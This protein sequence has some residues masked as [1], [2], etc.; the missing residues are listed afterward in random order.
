M[1]LGALNLTHNHLEPTT[2][3]PSKVLCELKYHQKTALTWLLARESNRL[4]GCLGGFLLDDTGLGK[5]LTM[6]ALAASTQSMLPTMVV[7]PSYIIPVWATEISKHTTIPNHKVLTYHGKN[8][9]EALRLSDYDVILTSYRAVGDDLVDHKENK[10]FKHG[11]LFNRRMHR[12]ILD[13]A[14]YIKNQN[15]TASKAC[16]ALRARTRWVVSATPIQNSI[17]EIWPYFRFLQVETLA[18]REGWNAMVGAK[19][20]CQSK[21]DEGLHTLQ[22]YLAD[23]AIKRDKSMLTL[24]EKRSS[25]VAL[26]LTD[27][28]REFY[29]A[30]FEYC[31]VRVAKLVEHAEHVS[32]Q[33][34][35]RNV[36]QN[37]GDKRLVNLK[38]NIFVLILRLRQA[39][40]HPMLVIS[41]M[42]RLYGEDAD[43]PRSVSRATSILRDFTS[44]HR[45]GTLEECIIC[46]DN[47]SHVVLHP[48]D[49]KC[50]RKCYEKMSPPANL[51]LMRCH[52]CDGMVSHTTRVK[53]RR[54]EQEV[55]SDPE[56]LA[57]STKVDMIVEEIR[58]HS[59]AHKIMV[60]S[61]W[62]TMINILQTIIQ[63]R[64]P[65]LKFVRLDGS[66]KT[67]QRI[68]LVD[69]VQND[70]RIRLV[71]VTLGSSAEGIT[72]TACTKV[73]FAD[74]W[75]NG[76]KE[77]Q[78]EDRTHRI[79]QCSRVDVVHYVINN[80]IEAQVVEMQK[81]KK[82]LCDM[83]VTNK[84]PSTAAGNW[85][86]KVRLM[87]KL[88]EPKNKKRSIDVVK[89]GS[90]E[91]PTYNVK[92]RKV[93][94][95]NSDTRV[96]SFQ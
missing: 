84:K 38:S 1:D 57:S 9:M 21:R 50:C 11:S 32:N 74:V 14:H 93:A 79:G 64:M 51:K 30:M 46:L 94:T 62:S 20:R 24:P 33:R 49:H 60:V 59:Q 8:R 26:E 15:T 18:G 65:D 13:E 7:C 72:L 92:Y 12:V 27:T 95:H 4:W 55:D 3:D 63:Q 5:T 89:V 40:C 23:L 73:Y 34:K 25:V 91:P 44:K 88:G 39:C 6:L 47:D 85:G 86:S 2:P 87:V 78:A 58:K 67:Q 41:G 43:Q 36:E 90:D 42:N 48:C 28:E 29:N 82:E 66:V 83:V 52:Y 17:E 70:P 19:L 81:Q 61:Q 80:T 69:K 10:A 53:R 68:E 22:Q 75:W 71:L 31:Q 45:Q 77:K 76:F 96:I 37:K 16:A 35:L 56:P 54:S